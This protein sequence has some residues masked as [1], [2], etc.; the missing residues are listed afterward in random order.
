MQESVI[1][2]LFFG[3]KNAFAC[4]FRQLFNHKVDG[5]SGL[6]VIISNYSK[7][8]QV[9]LQANFEHILHYTEVKYLDSFTK[10]QPFS[11]HTFSLKKQHTEPFF[12]LSVYGIARVACVLNFLKG[13]KML[14][15]NQPK[16]NPNEM[17]LFTISLYSS[18][19]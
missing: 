7:I 5:K 19:H 12:F 17:F 13:L 10:Y 9:L 11:V 3:H 15:K 16:K 14:F 4:R 8:E 1:K 2:I 6:F 18:Y